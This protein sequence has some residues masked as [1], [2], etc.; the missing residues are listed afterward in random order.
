MCNLINFIPVRISGHPNFVCFMHITQAAA[1]MNSARR[2]AGV[3]HPQARRTTSCRRRFLS[4]TSSTMRG[5]SRV[6][7]ASRASKSTLHKGRCSDIRACRGPQE[8]FWEVRRGVFIFSRIDFR[9][10]DLRHANWLLAE[11]VY[12]RTEVFVFCC[13]HSLSW[14]NRSQHRWHQNPHEQRRNGRVANGP[15]SRR[16][17]KSCITLTPFSALS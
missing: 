6:G 11:G 5:V 8:I 2:P 10:R 15:R 16:T 3:R 1:R 4:E 13:W 9:C 17:G 7:P 14:V 12:E